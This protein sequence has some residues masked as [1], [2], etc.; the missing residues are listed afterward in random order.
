MAEPASPLPTAAPPGRRWLAVVLLV[1]AGTA[2]AAGWYWA[3]TPAPPAVDLGAA[4]PAVADA[5][6]AARQAV[7]RSPRS[8]AAWGELGMVLQANGYAAEAYA[9][10]VEAERRDP[11]DPAWP[12]FQALRLLV[13]D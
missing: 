4:P 7:R 2:A 6:E 9:C 5:V 12:Y 3:D 1:A 8:G 11:R 10:F 13:H